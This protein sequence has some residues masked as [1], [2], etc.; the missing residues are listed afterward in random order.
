MGH[1]GNCYHKRAIVY[2]E[3]KDMLLP[4]LIFET[5]TYSVYWRGHLTLNDVEIR[6]DGSAELNL[7]T[8]E[9]LDVERAWQVLTRQNRRVKDL[10]LYRLMSFHNQGKS[11]LVLN[12]GLTGY[13][14]YQGTNVSKPSWALAN[15]KDKMANPL[16]ISVVSVTA[17]NMT[18]LQ[19]RSDI[20][21]EY[22]NRWHVTPSGHIHPPQSLSDAIEAEFL[23]EMGVFLN[24]MIEEIIVTG[25]VVNKEIYKPELTFFVRLRL[26]ADDI[27]NR[28]ARDNWE[29]KRL[30]AVEWKSDVIGEWLKCGGPH[31]VP[32]GHAA[33]VLGGGIEF[34]DEWMAQV[35]ASRGPF[36]ITP[37]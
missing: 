2:H 13:K 33:L 32:P 10:P 14:Q 1:A 22:G 11:G 17:D 9:K 16:A 27:L 12:L 36:W 23:E 25:L 26:T 30:Q 28:F 24:E 20:V 15:P 21:G 37:P 8:E 4:S 31:F 3:K 5:Q 19:L 7:S 34:G 6:Y 29:Y 18:I 35:L